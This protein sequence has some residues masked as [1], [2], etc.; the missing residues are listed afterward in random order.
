MSIIGKNIFYQVFTSEDFNNYKF[1]F[2]P[3][4]DLIKTYLSVCTIYYVHMDRDD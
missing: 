1:K 2:Q 3:R 4:I